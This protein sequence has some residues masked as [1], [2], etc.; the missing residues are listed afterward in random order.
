MRFHLPIEFI[1]QVI[2]QLTNLVETQANKK[3]FAIIDQSLM[4]PERVYLNSTRI[5]CKHCSH[6]IDVIGHF[7]PLVNRARISLRKATTLN[8]LSHVMPWKE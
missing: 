4:T 1:L 5:I 3:Q 2:N 6:L 8:T 7:L